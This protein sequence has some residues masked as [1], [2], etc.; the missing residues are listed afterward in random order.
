MVKFRRAKQHQM[1]R[2]K[3]KVPE[4]LKFLVSFRSSWVLALSVW[5][6]LSKLLEIPHAFIKI[7]EQERM[8]FK[9]EINGNNGNNVMVIM[10]DNNIKQPTY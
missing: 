4:E 3:L 7:T 9:S 2:S 8:P 5:L 6:V 1:Q 10:F